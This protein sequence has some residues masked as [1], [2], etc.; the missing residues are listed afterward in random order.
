MANVPGLRSP[1]TKVGR[2]VYFGRM[3]DKIRLMQTG[4][5][6]ADY[7]ANYGDANP[8]VFDARCCRFLGLPHLRIAE[9]VTST[10]SDETILEWCEQNGIRHSDEECDIWNNFMMKRGW[11]DEASSR[12]KARVDEYQLGGRGVET[13]FDLIEVDESRD[14]AQTRPF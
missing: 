11:R 1:Y 12:L 7:Q 10:K 5:L 14:P 13:F 9:Q 6:P 3:I 2:L 8:G 4:I